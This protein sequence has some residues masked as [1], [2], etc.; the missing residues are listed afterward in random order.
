MAV[1]SSHRKLIFA[2]TIGVLAFAN[3]SAVTIQGFSRGTLTISGS[4][5][6]L[7]HLG[8]S[9]LTGNEVLVLGT[10]LSR[11]ADWITSI[12]G[13][14]N[15]IGVSAQSWVASDS[16]AALRYVAR[17]DPQ[18]TAAWMLS[19]SIGSSDAMGSSEARSESLRMV[20]E[21][22]MAN[23]DNGESPALDI[24]EGDRYRGERRRG[25]T[26]S[27]PQWYGDYICSCSE[28]TDLSNFD[29]PVLA[30]PEPSSALLIGLGSLRL[31]IRR[32]RTS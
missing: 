24:I 20:I 32:R 28:S 11:S 1:S 23:S 12:P 31:L 9:V 14:G 25:S 4:L 6:E 5:N 16:S 15:S 21:A 30:V 27:V 18:N 13:T 3:A 8:N 22:W 2:A 7:P 29:I 17:N 26:D 10:G 19:V